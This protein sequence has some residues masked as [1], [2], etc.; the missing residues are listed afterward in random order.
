MVENIKIAPVKKLLAEEETFLNALTEK[1]ELIEFYNHAKSEVD[2]FIK[3]GTKVFQRKEIIF[4]EEELVTVSIVQSLA[5]FSALEIS[6]T[7]L[8]FNSNPSA[9]TFAKLANAYLLDLLTFVAASENFEASP[10]SYVESDI[11]LLYIFTITLFPELLDKTEFIFLKGLDHKQRARNNNIR[12]MKGSY[13]RDCTLYLAYWLAKEYKREES[14]TNQLL[15]YCAPTIESCYAKA[16]E[17]AF[18]NNEDEAQRIVY[19]LAQYHIKNSKTSDLTYPF[20]RNQWIYFPIEI[21]SLLK[22]REHKNIKN[23]FL[24]HPLINIFTPFVSA[25]LEIELDVLLLKNRF[26]N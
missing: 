7:I 19:E 4:G 9:D 23:D 10:V 15:S 3:S 17:N 11:G 13:G 16:V 2:I 25:K 20:H 22:I 18:S 6:K 12:P 24:S 14:V 26:F 1:Q 5:S 21:L 8:A